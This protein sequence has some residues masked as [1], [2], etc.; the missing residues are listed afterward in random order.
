MVQA[1]SGPV[2]TDAERY[3]LVYMIAVLVIV[4]ALI[5]LFFVVF[6]KR[7]NKLLF[8]KIRQQQVFEEELTK[9]QLE[10]QEQ[11]LKNVGRELHDNVGQILAFASMQLNALSSTVNDQ[12]KKGV[13]DVRELVSDSITEVRAI[14]KSLNS[15]VSLKLGLEASLENEVNRLNRLNSPKAILDIQGELIELSNKKDEIFIF[16][17]V[18]EFISNTLK[19]ADADMLT[20]SLIYKE[21]ALSI[22]IKDDGEGF[23]MNAIEQGSGLINMQSR[24]KL[25]NASCTISSE[26][27]KGTTLELHYPYRDAV[28][29][30]T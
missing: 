9:T 17:I 19:Y 11:T 10:I 15:D 30:L 16:R 2:S 3:L 29:V 1:Q 5:I 8:D 13:E 21:D 12:V 25:I 14:S 24:A 7:K 26:I 22:Q 6:T 23:N 4:A 18:Q 27:E 28:T 20:M